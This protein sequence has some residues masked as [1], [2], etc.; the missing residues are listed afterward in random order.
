MIINIPLIMFYMRGGGK[1]SGGVKSEQFTD[2]FGK[3]SLGNLGISSYTCANIN[4]GKNE[5]ILRFNC[6]YGTMRE[7][8]TYGLQKIDN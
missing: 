7:F 2:F 1:E 5:K 3:I 6:P 8:S 4:L